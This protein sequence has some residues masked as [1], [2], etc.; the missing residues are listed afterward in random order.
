MK[1]VVINERALRIL[2]W[3]IVGI[4]IVGGGMGTMRLLVATAPEAP[5]I[6]REVILPT[7]QVQ[8][9]VPENEKVVISAQG[10][11]AALR[12]TQLAAEVSGRVIEVSPRF[13]AGEVMKEGEL[14]LRIDP[15]DYRAAHANAVANLES[16]RLTLEVEGANAERARRDWENLGRGEA[17]DLVLRKPQLASARAAVT[18]AEASVAK[19]LRDLE[20]TEVRALYACRIER[21][22]LDLGATV[23]PG[24]PLADVMSLGEAEVRLPLSLEDYGY[25]QTKGDGKVIGEVTATADLGG[26]SKTWTGR[27]VRSEEFVE[28]STRSINVVALFE[29]ADGATPPPGLFVDAEVE[30]RTLQD[31]FVL[32][33]LAMVEPGK[34]M[35]VDPENRL[36]FRE[37]SVLRTSERTVIVDGGLKSG[38]RICVT[39]LN[40]PVDGMPVRVEDG[41]T[42]GKDA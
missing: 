16:A 1:G 31:V 23:A 10:E 37:V 7:V 42:E 24:T 20:R 41:E 29:N 11:V 21:T 26:V 25:I 18:S 34:V 9:V 14:L 28:S 36:R 6:P 17:S 3:L 12:R 5:K 15:A 4:V 27:L 35:V 8:T 2:G 33:R 13:E 32:P 40:A 38:E 39:P 30:G 22:H 19:A